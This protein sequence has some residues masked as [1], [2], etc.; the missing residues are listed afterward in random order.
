[1]V[2]KTRQ[3]VA[4]QLIIAIVETLKT[5][6]RSLTDFSEES[7]AILSHCLTEQQFK[8]GQTLLQTGEV[9]NSIFFICKGL[10]KSCYTNDGK[11]INTS[12]FFENDFASNIK[13]L[14]N[15][16]KSEYDII[17]YE[18]STTIVF[19]K[20]KLLNAYKNSQEIET[21]GRKLLETIVSKQEEHS[22]SFKL[23][24][25]R[26]RYEHLQL[27][28]PG[29]LQRISLTQAASYLGVSRETLSRIRGK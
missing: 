8:K 5:Y 18:H 24:A 14:T 4:H 3:I 11:E 10:C 7:W 17:A 13:S 23:L 1:V 12:F 27:T 20:T 29:F 22:N 26:E 28:Q 21:F 6:I 19:D 2:K 15:G 9:C 25:P 16:S